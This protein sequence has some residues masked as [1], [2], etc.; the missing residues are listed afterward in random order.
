MS[1]QDFYVIVHAARFP[2]QCVDSIMV[3]DNIISFWAK[4]K[5]MWFSHKPVED[6]PVKFI[7][8]SNDL[9]TN[10]SLIL[11]YDQI[12]RHPSPDGKVLERNKPAAFRFASFLALHVIHSD[13]FASCEAWQKV[14]VLLTLRHNKSLKIRST[15]SKNPSWSSDGS[16]SRSRVPFWT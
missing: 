1:L 4:N 15:G 3:L 2:D 13:Q 10:L 7:Q 6:F 5:S 14:F 12:Y 9:Q 16:F 8:Y 11:H